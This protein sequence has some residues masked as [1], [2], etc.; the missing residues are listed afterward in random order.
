M[1]SFSHLLIIS[2]F[3]IIA[4]LAIIPGC[5]TLVTEEYTDSFYIAQQ[6]ESVYVYIYVDTNFY[7]DTLRID[8]VYL[9]DSSC[10]ICHR[11]YDI[12]GDL[13]E[14]QW[15]NSRHASY[16]FIDTA[17]GCGPECHSLEAFVAEVEGQTAPDNSLLP[18]GCKACHNPHESRTME[19]RV[20]EVIPYTLIT[21]AI[22]EN[23]TSNVCVACHQSTETITDLVDNSFTDTSTWVQSSTWANWEKHGSSQAN[24]FMAADGFST[25]TALASTSHLNVTLTNGCNGCHFNNADGLT[26]GGHTFQLNDGLSYSF[27]SCNI[28]G[29]HLSKPIIVEYLDTLQTVNDSLLTE[30]GTILYTAGLVD[31]TIDNI[32]AKASIID[33]AGLDTNLVRM[34]YNYFFIQNDKSRGVHNWLYD[35]TLLEQSI[36]YVDSVL[37]P[38]T[39]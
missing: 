30:L 34:M 28:S 6:I 17:S 38:P 37:N 20:D 18:I 8:T 15:G 12:P 11:T 32:S 1:K 3:A 33:A 9:N 26:L 25:G 4:L 39:P 19:M 7:V 10:I 35:S 22:Y 27:T 16:D 2:F 14:A 36:Y 29:C 13:A 5:D 21:G 23:G 31:S 24:N